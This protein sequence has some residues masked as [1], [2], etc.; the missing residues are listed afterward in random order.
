[1]I[2]REIIMVLLMILSAGLIF[3][4]Y[5]YDEKDETIYARIN[6]YTIEDRGTGHRILLTIT[7][8]ENSETITKLRYNGLDYKEM[9]KA[10][11]DLKNY[12]YT[13]QTLM[14]CYNEHSDF[15]RGGMCAYDDLKLMVLVFASVIAGILILVG[16][17]S[18][19]MNISVAN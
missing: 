18:I 2:N 4:T 1:M 17:C 6:N 11:L 10:E 16:I 14:F 19:L 15:L 5:I 13:N 9:N 7:N 3:K 8:N 12:I